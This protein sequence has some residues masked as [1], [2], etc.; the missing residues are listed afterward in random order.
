MRKV[1]N[2]FG[3]DYENIYQ[4][5]DEEKKQRQNARVRNFANRSQ[6]LGAPDIYGPPET[7]TLQRAR[8]LNKEIE[9]L[10]KAEQDLRNQFQQKLNELA[11]ERAK[12]RALT[13]ESAS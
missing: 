13:N 4:N 7:R 3:L 5:A 11:E 9:Q 6:W 2:D 1:P 8:P 10:D 12:L